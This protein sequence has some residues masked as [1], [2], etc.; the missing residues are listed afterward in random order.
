MGSV[1]FD[2][3]VFKVAFPEFDEQTDARCQSA[4]DLA[5]GT[6]LDNTSASPIPEAPR[7]LLLNYLT[8]HLL[9][10]LDGSSDSGRTVGRLSSSSQ[11]SVSAT[12]T[13]QSGTASQDWY[14]QTQYGAT[15]WTA[16]AMYR[17]GRMM[18]SGQSGIGQS[19][20]F[21]RALLPWQ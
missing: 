16:S 17:T 7:T 20:A 14:M 13:L 4:F 9:T 1:V 21:G 11:G 10:L 18:A 6:L 15:Y 3:A 12:L 19:L 2:A 8:A 5:A